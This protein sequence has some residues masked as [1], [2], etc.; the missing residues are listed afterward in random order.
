MAISLIRPQTE[1]TKPPRALWVP[2]ELGRPFGPPSDAA[3]QKRVIL[4]ALRLLERERGPVI[5]EDFPEDDPRERPDPAWRTP[6]AKPDLDGASAT[7][8]AAA[9]EDES[10]RVEAAYRRAA[11]ERERTIVGLSG[12]SIGEAGRYMASWLRGQTPESPSAEM[13]APLTLRFAV[14]DL[15][16]AYIEVALSGSAKPSSKQLGDWLWN[17]TAAGAA[18]F[19]LRSMYLTSDDERLKA[20]AG[21]FLVPGVRVPPSGSICARAELGRRRSRPIPSALAVGPLLP[22]PSEIKRL[23]IAMGRGSAMAL[24]GAEFGGDDR[25]LAGLGVLGEMV[26]HA[27]L[28]AAAA[29]LDIRARPLDIRLTGPDHRHAAQHG[30]LAG[31]REGGEIL[32]DAGPQPSLAGLNPGAMLLDLCSAGLAH[33]RLPAPLRRPAPSARRTGQ[34]SSLA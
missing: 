23:S 16:A 33:G 26:L 8:L 17:D 15:K 7:R 29:G 3:F 20:I 11:K 24:A 2:F 34:R 22:T 5:I 28:D 30:S 25:L 9:L 12:L 32:L 13:S 1:N 27:G 19:A 14:D 31:F 6:F 4:A 18:I 10:E 21:L